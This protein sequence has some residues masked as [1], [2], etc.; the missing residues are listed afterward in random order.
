MCN[1]HHGLNIVSDTPSSTLL[2]SKLAQHSFLDTMSSGDR[3][4]PPSV[5]SNERYA[6][7]SGL[8][9]QFDRSGTGE[10]MPDGRENLNRQPHERYPRAAQYDFLALNHHDFGY[11]TGGTDASADAQTFNR[12][13]QSSSSH[14]QSQQSHQRAS[15]RSRHRQTGGSE[16]DGG[17]DSTGQSRTSSGDGQRGQYRGSSHTVVG[18]RESD[19]GSRSHSGLSDGARRSNT[20]GGMGLDYRSDRG[21]SSTFLMMG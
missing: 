17:R 10:S 20:N 13:N 15:D 16:R 8:G 11:G 18:P 9:A 3:H 7:F 5:T 1:R 4:V 2:H 19:Q 12:Q 6:A 21:L 14:G